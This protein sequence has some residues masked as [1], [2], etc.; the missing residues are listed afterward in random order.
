[1][2]TYHIQYDMYHYYFNTWYGSFNLEVTPTLQTDNEP[3][4]LSG[5]GCLSCTATTATVAVSVDEPADIYWSVLPD[6]SATPTPSQ[7]RQ[8]GDFVTTTS[9]G[10]ATIPLSGLTAGQYYTAFFVGTDKASPTPNESTIVTST[11]FATKVALTAYLSL[12][13]I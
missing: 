11:Q 13:H 4:I 12:I 1:M 2:T 6:A 7:L 9:P 10:Q 8:Q 3:P 5:A